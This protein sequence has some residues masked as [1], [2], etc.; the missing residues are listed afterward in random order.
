MIE[1]LLK[2]LVCA[3]VATI[4]MTGCTIHESSGRISE[5]DRQAIAEQIRMELATIPSIDSIANTPVIV[6]PTITV[7]SRE[8]SDIREVLKMCVICIPF[9]FVIAVL[10]IYFH[11]TRINLL[12]KYQVI[13]NA[14][15]KGIELPDAFYRGNKSKFTRGNTKLLSNGMIWIA[16]GITGII[17]FG[18]VDSEEMQALCVLP[19]LVGITKIVSFMVEKRSLSAS[20]KSTDVDEI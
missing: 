5:F 2:L 17:F 4:A 1:K 19:V 16:F 11:Y 15:D 13:N 6:S 8:K 9:L 12:S 14:I 7:D 20:D 18:I 10:W 3:T